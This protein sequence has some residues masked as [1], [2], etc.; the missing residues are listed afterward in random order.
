M[1]IDQVIRS[2][3]LAWYRERPRETLVVKTKKAAKP[4]LG[5]QSRLGGFPYLPKGTTWPA[6]SRCG[7]SLFFV[8]QFG[9][10]LAPLPLPKGVNLLSV[11]KCSN[12]DCVSWSDTLKGGPFFH[13][14]KAAKG[15]AQQSP[16]SAW[17]GKSTYPPP[18]IEFDKFGP[19]NIS[20]FPE[21][22]NPYAINVR[23]QEIDYPN[24]D[25]CPSW[26]KIEDYAFD[27]YMELRPIAG[28]K[29]FGH[30]AW[31]QCPKY[32]KCRCRRKMKQLIQ[33]DWPEVTLGDS[34]RM[35]VFY[36]DRWC[37]GASALAAL[38]QCS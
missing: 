34:G 19:A 30:P 27:E 35:H 11:F 15:S 3:A 6:C 37:G 36:C 5:P 32:P 24:W 12:M 2:P 21:V 38:W 33:L 7:I 17:K 18:G 1:K 25:E 20:I 28:I 29:L 10:D 22:G 13:L 31:V 23:K 26:R 4:I 9:R 16:D 8:G 14:F